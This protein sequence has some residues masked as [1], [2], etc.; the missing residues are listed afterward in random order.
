MK[1]KQLV[2]AGAIVSSASFANAAAQ[3]SEF[4][5]E[6]IRVEGLMTYLRN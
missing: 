1:L 3:D 5:V 6:D 2:A 4:V